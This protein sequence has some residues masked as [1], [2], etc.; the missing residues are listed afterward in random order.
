[1]GKSLDEIHDQRPMVTASVRTNGT[2]G[3]LH[4]A[5]KEEVVYGYEA[6]AT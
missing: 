3:D 4:V 1:M 5:A 6:F 2:A